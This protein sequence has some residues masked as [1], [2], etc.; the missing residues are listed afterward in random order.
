MSELM[1]K[2]FLF[3]S[4]YFSLVNGLSVTLKD[5]AI[6]SLTPPLYLDGSDWTAS[7]SSL[8]INISA[9]VPGDV[10]T[11]LQLAGIISDPWYELNFL[12]NRSLWDTNLSWVYT[13]NV[14]LPPQ[15]NASNSSSLLVFEGVRMGAHVI[16]NGVELGEVTNQFMRYI[17]SLPTDITMFGQMNEISLRFDSSLVLNGRFVAS[18]AGWDWM[19]FSKVMMTDPTFGEEGRLT[20]GLWKSLYIIADPSPLVI[21]SVVPLVTYLGEY[22]VSPL[23][24]G[25]HGGFNVTV[26]AN[27]L[28]T[29]TNVV[30]GFFTASGEWGAIVESPLLTCPPGDSNVTFT[31]QA[32]ASLIKLWWPNGLGDHPLFNVSV[33]WKPSNSSSKEF[34]PPSITAVRKIGFRVAAL[35]TVN[36]TNAT[37]VSESKGANGSGTFGMF[38]RINGAAIFSRG[39][40]LVPTDMLDGRLD[41]IAYLTLVQSAAAAHFN[42]IRIWGG[43]IYPP[44]VFYDTCDTEGILLYHDMMFAGS[45]HDIA[46]AKQPFSSATNNSILSEISHQIRRLSHHPS[47]ILYDSANEVIVQKSGPTALYTSLVIATI[48]KEDPSRIIWPA[49]PAAGWQSGVDRL[50][51]TPNGDELIPIGTGHIWDAGN[52]RH[53]TYLA[54]VGAGNWSTV[55]RDPWTQDHTFDPGTPLAYLPNP[56]EQTGVAYP[57]VFASEFGTM[58]MSSFEAM[59]SSLDESSWGIHGGNKPSNCTQEPDNPFS[60]TCTGRNAMAQRNW[61]CDNLIWSYFGPN[62]LNLSG[63]Y[64]FKGQL[65][66]CLIASSIHMQLDIEQRRSQNYLGSLYWMFQESWNTG[67]WGSIEYTSASNGTLLGGRWKPTHNWLESHLFR[68]VM[69]ACGYIGRSKTFVCFVSNASPLAAFEGTL[70]ITSVDIQSGNESLWSSLPVNVSLGPGALSWVYPK[71]SL[72]NAS[73]TILIASLIDANGTS[74]DEHIVHLTA[75]V[76][77]VVPMANVSALVASI[78]NEDGS[79]N[80][81]VTSNTVALFVTLT[82]AAVGRFS[83]NSFLLR[84]QTSPKVVKW[85]PFQVGN[86]TQDLDI[87][88]RTLRV[89][90][91][92]D[93][94]NN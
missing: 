69:S 31:L 71:A 3:V 56:G 37:I 46:Q 53:G 55:V 88:Q 94:V 76:H 87:L 41:A 79:V 11:D 85:I 13:K 84:T 23:I 39:A 58:S 16:W 52:E 6:S 25:Q 93:Y 24:E 42:M 44:D 67:G 29:D 86:S 61:A 18:A 91:L 63:V 17:F 30:S 36:D 66:Q 81:T 60:Q 92:S 83:D 1:L 20:L 72:P 47:I 35:V 50:Y 59:S 77:I 62:L 10:I 27:I 5:Q 26:T 74:S 4:Y 7:E 48:A 57:S 32:P 34:D 33:S 40:N 75:P 43:G 64:A 19:A 70:L 12:D 45:G 14:F 8:G 73:T 80:I 54:G 38:F 89:E 21:T 90:D 9:T 78:P 2:S 51:G 49:S 15:S 22:P 65:F 28:V 68:D 82:S